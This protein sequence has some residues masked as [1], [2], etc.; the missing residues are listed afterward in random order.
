MTVTD[1][2][3]RSVKTARVVLWIQTGFGLFGAAFFLVFA[4]P[5]ARDTGAESAGI[6]AIGLAALLIAVVLGL[7]ALRSSSRQSWV[8]ITAIVIEGV[9]IAGGVLALVQGAGASTQAIGFALAA[10]VIVHMLKPETAAW[11]DR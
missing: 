3:P 2:M 7:L 9:L 10:V 11:F 4:G 6:L 1:T 8:R 5:I